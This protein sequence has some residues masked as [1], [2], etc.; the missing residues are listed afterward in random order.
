M[1]NRDSGRREARVAY[2]VESHSERYG[3]NVS[4]IHT[5][6]VLSLKDLLINMYVIFVKI[7]CKLMLIL[8]H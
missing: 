8:N 3:F 6:I 5:K 2:L 1:E 4:G 7:L